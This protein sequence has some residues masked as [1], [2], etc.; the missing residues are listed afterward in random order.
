MKR[1][2][3]ITVFVAALLLF[4]VQPMAGRMILPSFGGSALVWNSAMVFYQ[5]LLLLGYVYAHF[6][7]R[8]L[9]VERQPF[10][11][12]GLM[13]CGLVAFPLFI[14]PDGVQYFDSPSLS[15]VATLA[16]HVGLPFFIVSASAPMLQRWY[17]ATDADDADNP[18][19]LY[20]ASNAGS[21]LALF[22]YPLILEP[23]FDLER[24]GLVWSLGYIGLI[25]LTAAV[26]FKA[27]RTAVDKAVDAE[28][29]EWRRRAK[30]VGLAFIPSSLLLGVTQYITADIASVPLLWVVPLMLYLVSFIVAF[31]GSE[32]PVSRRFVGLTT[33]LLY[34]L[35]AVIATHLRDPIWLLLLLHLAAFSAVCLVF[36][37][38]VYAIRPAAQNLTDFYI[39]VSVGGVLGGIFNALIAPNIFDSYFE[40]PLVLALATGTTWLVKSVDVEGRAETIALALAAVLSTALVFTIAW[41]TMGDLFRMA[42]LV[43]LATAPF[44]LHFVRPVVTPI[45]MAVACLIVTS[46]IVRSESLVEVRS[47]YGSYRVVKSDTSMSDFHTLI[48]GWTNHGSQALRED[49]KD[50][51]LSY[52]HPTSPMGEMVNSIHDG[53]QIAVIGLGA[54][55]LAA[56]GGKQRKMLLLEIDPLVVELASNPKYFTYLDTC[57]TA[58]DVRVGDGRL[59]LNDVPD[60]SLAAIVLDAY[61]SDS[62]PVHL[63]TLE[64]FDLYLSKLKPGG[65]VIFHVSNKYLYL[66]RL[67]ARLAHERQLDA[68][69]QQHWLRQKH[70][71]ELNMSESDVVVVG[72]SN[73]AVERMRRDPRWKKLVA[74]LSDPVWTDT[75]ANL[76]P[77]LDLGSD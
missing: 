12:L 40:Y 14:S 62:I 5:A 76:L 19:L 32:W 56:Y 21:L 54:G 7:I 65:I 70:F 53:S 31:G 48:H 17:A 71:Y 29:V 67:V 46:P 24:Q 43:L 58:C 50:V 47:A 41:D 23:L 42:T 57:G 34:I 49:L 73:D 16:I 18:Y 28:T 20:A 72:K 61:N 69:R 30:W 64:A 33:A 2:F 11:H 55:V 4:V 68:F 27:P 38:A 26:A 51:P 1:L 75:Y 60:N 9:G 25:V 74:D 35:I 6:S 77:Y 37:G 59:L 8:W 10:V 44:V 15:V 36:H 52:Y 63:I 13:L 22:A 39:W 3:A 66:D 45:A